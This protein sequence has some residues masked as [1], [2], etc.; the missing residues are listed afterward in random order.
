MTIVLIYVTD[1]DFVINVVGGKVGL[2]PFFLVQRDK[3]LSRCSFRSEKGIAVVQQTTIR[4]GKMS[5]FSP[6]SERNV[7][8]S[9]QIWQRQSGKFCPCRWAAAARLQNYF[10]HLAQPERLGF[11]FIV[12]VICDSM[13]NICSDICF[14]FEGKSM[15]S[16]QFPAASYQKNNNS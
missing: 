8:K 3:S 16:Y 2:S 5:D 1:G 4:M 11:I 7:R 15:K 12:Q 6:I 13:L 10:A 9:R 14:D